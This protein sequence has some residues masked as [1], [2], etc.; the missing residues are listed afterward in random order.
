MGAGARKN[1]L[2]D[3]SN[4]RCPAVSLYYKRSIV[5]PRMHWSLRAMRDTSRYTISNCSFASEP[6]HLEERRVEAVSILRTYSTIL[7]VVFKIRQQQPPVL[8]FQGIIMFRSLELVLLWLSALVVHADASSINHTNGTNRTNTNSI[9]FLDTNSSSWDS[10]TSSIDALSSFDDS[11]SIDSIHDDSSSDKAGGKGSGKGLLNKGYLKRFGFRNMRGY[12]N[13]KKHGS[14]INDSQGEG[15]DDELPSMASSSDQ[16]TKKAPT[17][18]PVP[19]KVPHT[20]ALEKASAS[21]GN[22]ND[23]PPCSK[24]NYVRLGSHDCVTSLSKSARGPKSPAPTLPSAP[25]TVTSAP[26]PVTS[27][28]VTVTAAPVNEPPVSLAPISPASNF[29]TANPSSLSPSTAA[30]VYHPTSSPT[31]I[32]SAPPSGQKG[33]RSQTQGKI[34][35]SAFWT[36]D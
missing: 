2:V 1:R 30:P 15:C 21:N 24:G 6:T 16:S 9:S 31:G 18:S 3:A 26:V 27:T 29:P 25:A 4:T 36:F 12:R 19:S 28:Q 20:L 33:F 22:S 10:K 5:E 35:A 8:T 34:I 32:G 11:A 7:A 17:L 14:N 13:A 23:P